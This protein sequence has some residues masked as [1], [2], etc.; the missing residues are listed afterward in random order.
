MIFPR[1]CFVSFSHRRFSFRVKREAARSN[2]LWRDAPGGGRL[3]IAST[4]VRA[5]AAGT[6]R[7]GDASIGAIGQC[8]AL[9][10][11]EPR[12]C[13]D[14][15]A[16]V[17]RDDHGLAGR[18]EAFDPLPPVADEW[19]AARGGLEEAN[20][21]GP[22]GGHH[23][24]PRY[25]QGESLAAVELGMLA[26]RQMFDARDVFRPVDVLRIARPGHD[27]AHV[28]QA[29][30]RLDQQAF[31]RGLPVVAEGA[32]IAEVPLGG[33]TGIAIGV[34]VD[35]AIEGHRPPRRELV[36]QPSSVLPPEK[37]K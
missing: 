4:K 31:E 28:R 30:R 21:R 19:R 25:V 18:E 27:E 16:A 13:R 26:G 20:A 22:A 34:E 33:R 7:G 23:V 1:L 29:P 35:G 2:A 8:F 6:V 11:V 10:F 32:E 14:D 36:P 3:S 17:S 37:E 9:F 12:Q 5:R 24:G 15:I